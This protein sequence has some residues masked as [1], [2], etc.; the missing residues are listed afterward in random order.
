MDI[1]LFKKYDCD[2]C[3]C[4]GFF[5]STEAHFHI[6]NNNK[7][8]Y[9]NKFYVDDH[10]S[11]NILTYG[12]NT[13][14][15]F[16][17]LY[18]SI[19]YLLNPTINLIHKETLLSFNWQEFKNCFYQLID[20]MNKNLSIDFQN[21]DEI[22]PEIKEQIKVLC[23]EDN[24]L[25]SFLSKCDLFEE[26]VVN[27][28]FNDNSDYHK[29]IN[30]LFSLFNKTIHD[31]NFNY[32]NHLIALRKENAENYN[33]DFLLNLLDELSFDENI[34]KDI[35]NNRHNF[36]YCFNIEFKP[37]LKSS[38]SDEAIVFT[39]FDKNTNKIVREDRMSKEDFIYSFEFESINTYLF[40]LFNIG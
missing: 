30:E 17:S 6:K 40:N 19:F 5:S 26:M 18:N 33:H 4:C 34:I 28:Y 36:Q 32:E 27:L 21:F 15:E 3:E 29:S 10:L 20:L 1:S 37:D 12:S 7:T 24:L 11:Q 9:K 2:E 22:T 14:D 13:S 8:I 35:H 16:I 39:L 31:K 23:K 38:K 25:I